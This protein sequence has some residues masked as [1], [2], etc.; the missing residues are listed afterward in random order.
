MPAI[1]KLSDEDHPDVIR[2]A[3][4]LIEKHSHRI[5]QLKSLFYFVRD[6]IKFGFPRTWDRVKASETLKY[7]IGYCN[8]KATLFHALCKAA[9]IPSRIHTALIDIRIMDGIIPA[10]AFLLLPKKGS[11]SWI[12]IELDGEWMPLDSYINDRNLYEGALEKLNR[13]H[14]VTAY[15]ISRST[16]A[17]SCEFNF[18]EK[19]FVHMGA[20]TDDHG[21]WDDFSDYMKT[22]GYQGLDRVQRFF[23]PILASQMNRNIESLRQ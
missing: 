3:D 14:K 9:G 18:G 21:T 22:E 20:V 1:E 8:T 15:S 12:E 23:F 11:H 5:D 4:K 16:G 7:G 19:G 10:P 17:S 13:E 2:K 6:G